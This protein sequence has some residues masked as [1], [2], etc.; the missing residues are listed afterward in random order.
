[1]KSP[2]P[3]VVG[4]GK[5]TPAEILAVDPL[6]LRHGGAI[7]RGVPEFVFDD[8]AIVPCHL[9]DRQPALNEDMIR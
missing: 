1:M 4:F 2:A 6:P 7:T 8:G 3:M 5:L 9:H